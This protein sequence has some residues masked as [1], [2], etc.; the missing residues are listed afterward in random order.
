MSEQ[1]DEF[2]DA[3]VFG[4][5][6]TVK[7]LLKETPAL[8]TGTDEYGF[9]ALHGAVGED[10][11]EMAK[12]LIKKGADVNAKNDEGMTPL[13]IA[14]YGAMVKI[15]VKNGAD[16]N[17]QSKDGS[18][19]LHTQATEGADTGSV[20]VLEALL[21]AGADPNVKD[22]AGKTPLDYA[23]QREEDEKVALLNAHGAKGR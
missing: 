9:T 5:V 6:D 16:V 22:K 7:A 4:D 13:H 20:E 8:V 14:A 15:L 19:P 10:Q 11:E 17:S 3:A 18:T 12:L 21:D 1:F 2:Y 23:R